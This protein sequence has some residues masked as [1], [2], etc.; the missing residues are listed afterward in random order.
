LKEKNMKIAL[1]PGKDK[2][3]KLLIAYSLP[4]VIIMIL[5]ALYNAADRIFIGQALG[6]EGIAA[7]T[8]F[9]PITMAALALGCLFGGTG[10][11]I[12]L[13]LGADRKEEAEKYLA[14]GLALSAAAS[15]LFAVLILVFLTPVLRAFG[16]TDALLPRAAAYGQ[17]ILIGFLF[18]IPSMAV[19]GSLHA[20]GRPGWALAATMAGTIGNLILDPLFIFGFGWGIEG[21]AWATI[22]AP[23][24][25]LAL[26]LAF[27]Q[28]RQSGLRF[29]KMSFR[30]GRGYTGPIMA[31][32]LPVFLVQFIGTFAF[33][34]AN[35]SFSGLGGAAGLAAVGIINTAC[36][37]MAFPLIGVIQGAMTVWGYAQ[38]AGRIDRLRE[39]TRI[40][41]GIALLFGIFGTLVS[42]IFPQAIVRLFNPGDPAL[43]ELGARGMRIFMSAFFLY[44]V[45]ALAAHYFIS[46]G[47]PRQAGI[48]LL[49]R[50]FL[51][52]ALFIVLPRFMG[53]DGAFLA[54]PVSDILMAALSAAL[55]LSENRRLKE[56][57][58]GIRERVQ[59]NAEKLIA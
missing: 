17:I 33:I 42:E 52:T 59:K 57:E 15:L 22:L 43:V 26:T 50:S 24:G 46:I 6:T 30:A 31:K 29:R 14:R 34:A 8:V 19:S 48:V 32:G 20:Q 54:G 39:T 1:D 44:S 25:S 35:A 7:V 11:M 12:T 53:T 10:T 16:A 28:K 36:S 5:N 47:K 4:A 3:G 13:N 55:L 56:A 21:A 38:G 9:F 49:S 40:T 45:Q 41:L 2:I 51:L 27:I 18:Q 58:A 37:F 23:A